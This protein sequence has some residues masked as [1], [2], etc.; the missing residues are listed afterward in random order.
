MHM[1]MLK[2]GLI[3]QG[4]VCWVVAYCAIMCHFDRS[5]KNLKNFG[6]VLH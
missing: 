1:Q 2:V 3:I 6:K 5:L 4:G